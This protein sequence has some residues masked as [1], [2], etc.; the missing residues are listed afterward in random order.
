MDEAMLAS[1]NPLRLR[2]YEFPLPKEGDTL[3]PTNC[4]STKEPLEKHDESWPVLYVLTSESE[5]AAYIGETT[6]YRR[7][8]RQHSNNADKQK[9]SFDKTLLIDSP[10]FNQ[11]VT[12][13]FE[14]RL[15]ELF[16]ADEQYT[17][18]NKNNGYSQ[19]DYFNRIEYRQRFR[20]LWGLL[21]DGG[22]AIHGIEELE[23]SDLFKY[24]P[25]KTLT[26]DQADTI[27]KILA[28]IKQNEDCI[29]LV[30]GM[31][32]TGKT[33]LAVTL[34]FKLA[35][36]P[37]FKAKKIGFVSPMDSLRAT[38]RKTVKTLP[39][40]KAKDIMG[41]SDVANRM[42]ESNERYDVLVIDEAHR[43]TDE[44]GVQGVKTYRDTCEKIG[45]P[46][47][48]DHI[49]WIIKCCKMP[50]FFYDK[51][52]KVKATGLG[53]ERFDAKMTELE[54]KG[55]L[56]KECQLTTQMR[57][58]GGDEYLDLVYDLL[59][60]KMDRHR[61]FE[62]TS[63][64][65]RK[66][67]DPS[68]EPNQ[69]MVP[70]YQLGLFKDFSSFCKLQQEKEGEAGLSR[71]MAGYA[72]PWISKKDEAAFDIT[73]EGIQKRWNSTTK[74]WVNS[75]NALEEVGSIHTI[76]GY[77]LNYGFVIIGNDLKFDS[78]NQ[79]VIV[80][81]QGFYDKGAKKTSDE[82]TLREVIINAYYV[83]LTRGTLGTFIYVCDPAL[84]D[85][86]ARWIPY[87]KL[88]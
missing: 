54:N 47:S 83:L 25:F 1:E 36:E 40:L 18:T 29:T 48:A 43:L 74:D 38:L 60:N 41:P 76:Q 46:T 80:N 26:P 14:N 33:I 24:S 16:M 72:W 68:K 32:G 13:D 88:D 82:N 85:Y 84:R 50:I 86:M 58:R 66:P 70:K 52:Q 3:Q 10:E 39:G 63:I 30:E 77:D 56:V 44:K 79:Q 34:L 21:K 22:Y 11:S 78:E 61:T 17:V 59:D 49:D 73:I 5:H 2:Q 45:L 23:N 15:I 62:F 37:R 81:R 87:I 6:N 69:E 4:Y 31:P 8:M 64:F 19:T 20:E 71:M 12:F 27:E 51:K 75:D 65:S 9:W 57:V 67:F 42:A 35:N 55:F 7:R 53:G 28:T